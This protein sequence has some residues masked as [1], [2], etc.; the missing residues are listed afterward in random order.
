MVTMAIMMMSIGSLMI[1]ITNTPIITIPAIITKVIITIIEIASPISTGIAS[2]EDINLHLGKY[3]KSSCSTKCTP[4]FL[5][6]TITIAITP[7]GGITI[8]STH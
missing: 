2:L 5:H 4:A 7:I 6:G 8:V 3:S 1:I